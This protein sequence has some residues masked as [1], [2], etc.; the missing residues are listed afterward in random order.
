MK[1]SKKA[2]DSFKESQAKEVLPIQTIVDAEGHKYEG[3]TLNGMKH[4]KG[5]LLFEDGAFYEGEFENDAIN[6]HGVLYYR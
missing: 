3:E 6:G 2:E 1:S 5:K 4:G